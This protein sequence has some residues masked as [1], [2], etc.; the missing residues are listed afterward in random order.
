M[1]HPVPFCCQWYLTQFLK[2]INFIENLEMTHI[3]GVRR[4]CYLRHYDALRTDVTHSLFSLL[5]QACKIWKNPLFKKVIQ[6]EKSW[7]TNIFFSFDEN[8]AQ[9]FLFLFLF[10]LDKSCFVYVFMTLSFNFRNNIIFLN[11]IL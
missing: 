1:G 4:S 7:S 10:F 3:A 9:F 2:T 6:L 5:I 8:V 11:Y